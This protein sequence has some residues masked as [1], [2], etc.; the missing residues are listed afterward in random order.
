MA[1]EHTDDSNTKGAGGMFSDPSTGDYWVS[2]E[3]LDP[4]IFFTT[5]T[6]KIGNITK[7]MRFRTEEGEPASRIIYYK[8]YRAPHYANLKQDYQKLY[9]ATLGEKKNE[10]LT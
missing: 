7:P 6:M 8:N 4:V 5:D 1:K 10:V 2:T 3:G 9:G